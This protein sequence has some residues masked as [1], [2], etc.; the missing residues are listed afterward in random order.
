MA[1]ATDQYGY[2][3]FSWDR[4]GVAESQHGEPVNE[5][6]SS[7]EI[8]ALYNLTT[9]LR[10]GEIPGIDR[11]FDKVVHVGHS[12]G[13]I[14][15][16]SLVVLYPEASD[17]LV[18]TGFS[19]TS[20]YIPYFALS[21][22]LVLANQIPRLRNYPDGYFAFGALSGLQT[23]LFSPGGFDPELLKLGYSSEQP[24]AIG[25]LLTLFAQTGVSNPFKGPV[26]I[27]T[28]GKPNHYLPNISEA[29]TRKTDGVKDVMS[30]SVAAIAAIPGM[31][32]SRTFSNCPRRISRP[33]V[34]LRL[35][36]SEKQDMG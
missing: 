26:L 28:G 2:S 33:R 6:Q 14:I 30:P 3:T 4:L 27:I 29:K 23:V 22:D 34:S 31:P 1:E 13:S 24:V 9:R 25:E 10:G 19:Q 21:A 18:L 11:T 16:Y 7:L 15:S 35:L 8:A 36:S 20:E 5:I 17:G 12:F 32:L